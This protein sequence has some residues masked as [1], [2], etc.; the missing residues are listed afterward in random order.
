MPE[1]LRVLQVLFRND[2]EKAQEPMPL[3]EIAR[4]AKLDRGVAMQQLSQWELFDLTRR[5]NSNSSFG[6]TQKAAD[7]LYTTDFLSQGDLQ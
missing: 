6:L 3:N 5:G 2:P 7:E 1:L 4:R